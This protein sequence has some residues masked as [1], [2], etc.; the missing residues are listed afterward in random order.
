MDNEFDIYKIGEKKLAR[1]AIV[2][3]EYCDVKCYDCPDNSD[4]KSGMGKYCNCNDGYEGKVRI[5][6]DLDLDSTCSLCE[7][8]KYSDSNSPSLDTSNGIKTC[9]H[10]AANMYS[11]EKGKSSCEDCGRNYYSNEGASTCTACPEGKY[12]NTGDTTPCWSCQ[13]NHVVSF[14]R[15]TILCT[16]CEPNEYVNDEFE[17]ASCD[18]LNYGIKTESGVRVC[19]ECKVTWAKMEYVNLDGICSDL[20]V[21]KIGYNWE[22]EGEDQY[23][24]DGELI[25]LSADQYL[26][27]DVHGAITSCGCDEIFHYAQGCGKAATK[28]EVWVYE[29]DPSSPKPDVQDLLKIESASAEASAADYRIYRPGKCTA[30]PTCP[31]GQYSTC[32]GASAGE[33][34]NCSTSCEPGHYLSRPSEE[35]FV[36]PKQWCS[37]KITDHYPTRDLTCQKC[38]AWKAVDGGKY[39]LV[40]GCGNVRSFTRW[41]PSREVTADGERPRSVSCDVESAAV[42]CFVDGRTVPAD[43]YSAGEYLPYCPPGWHVNAG[44]VGTDTSAAWNPACCERC[45]TCDLAAGKAV[46][47]HE[48]AECSGASAADTQDA[49]DSACHV[50]E[51][52]DGDQCRRC[53]SCRAGELYLGTGGGNI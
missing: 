36:T 2:Q 50:G 8:G 17:C 33:C 46:R 48:Y 12:R 31:D 27:Q 42:D 38:P 25:V 9:L 41:D 28:T 3:Y 5:D 6:S 40:A 53:T 19:A 35:E 16:P 11:N 13:A 10:C 49:C 18:I 34:I 45:T 15:E 21:R 37:W 26:N 47:L 39:Y 52:I 29:F 30:C 7:L 1:F 23:W 44:C 43:A 22:L 20:P 4:K 32:A 51:Y 24:L 14:T